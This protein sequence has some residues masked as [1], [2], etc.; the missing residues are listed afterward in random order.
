MD[1]SILDIS[2]KQAHV[3]RGLMSGFL[4][5]NVQHSFSLSVY[6]P[7]SGLL[8]RM[9][10]MFGFSLANGKHFCKKGSAYLHSLT[11]FL[12]VKNAMV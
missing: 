8:G 3:I 9:V 5:V 10:C 12:L 1:L 7:R 11:P 4:V 6:T 2:C